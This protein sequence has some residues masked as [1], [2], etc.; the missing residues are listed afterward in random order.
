LFTPPRG[1]EPI[2][3][4]GPDLTTDQWITIVDALSDS[5]NRDALHLAASLRRSFS[6]ARYR[7]V[8]H[9][10]ALAE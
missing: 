5:E 6:E 8:W 1:D 7:K 10:D 3:V 9:V 2:K 4:I